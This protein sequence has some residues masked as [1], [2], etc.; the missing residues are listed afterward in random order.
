MR[1]RTCRPRVEE[2][3][4]RSI[5]SAT[6]VPL[7]PAM[8]AVPGHITHPPATGMLRGNYTAPMPIPDVG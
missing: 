2:L 1:N 4:P 5:P 6:G 8:P 7:L 3:E